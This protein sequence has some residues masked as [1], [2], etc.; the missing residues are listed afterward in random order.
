MKKFQFTDHM[1]LTLKKKEEQSVDV[2]V[3]LR[4]GIKTLNGANME[5][6]CGAET[7]EQAIQRLYNLRIHPIYR[8]QTKTLLLM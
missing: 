6:K 3:L 1:K 8:H 7:E 5:T 2:S 4:R